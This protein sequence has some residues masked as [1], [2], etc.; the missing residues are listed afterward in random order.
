MKRIR[1]VVMMVVFMTLLFFKHIWCR[2][3]GVPS[4][5]MFLL[6]LC[7]ARLSRVLGSSKGILEPL[8]SEH[9]I[10]QQAPW[11]QKDFSPWVPQC[12][13]LGWHWFLQNGPKG[14]TKEGQSTSTEVS[15]VVDV[16][17]NATVWCSILG[18]LGNKWCARLGALQRGCA[19][20]GLPPCEMV[21]LF[22][23]I[24]T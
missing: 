11:F 4:A 10:G 3:A 16:A 2:F 20:G 5:F 8:P 7:R 9:V 1:I 15:V 22:S 6:L 12:D 13:S 14:R 21:H 18:I 24:A 19:L 17:R 23:Q